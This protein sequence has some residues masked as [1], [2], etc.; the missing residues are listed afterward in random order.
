[1]NTYA[2]K[3]KQNLLSLIYGMEANELKNYVRNPDTDF[4]R[5]RKFG[6]SAVVRFILSMGS[7]TLG[8]EL[9]KF[10]QFNP[11]FPSVSA[12]V[13]QRQKIKPE[14]FE[15][16]FH[17]F[18]S[19]QNKID[20]FD[21]YR[22]LAVDG[23]DVILPLNPDEP[24]A[25]PESRCSILHL[26]ALFD[27]INRQY[28]DAVIQGKRETNEIDAVVTMTERLS[29]QFPVIIVADR[30]YESYNFFAHVEE[31]LFDYVVRIRSSKNRSM[32]SGLCLPEKEAFDI[33]KDVVIT[34]HSTGPYM[35]NKEKYKYMTKQARFD[36]IP[37]SK[38]PD[39]EMSIRFVSFQLETGEF[40]ILA[41][42]LPEEIFSAEQLKEIYH[43]R[44]GIETAFRSVKHITGLTA[45]HTKK[46]DC[47]FQEIYARL[48]MYNFSMLIANKVEIPEE[49]HHKYRYLANFAQA[50]RI[51]MEYFR[52]QNNS[53]PLDLQALLPRFILPERKGRSYTRNVYPQGV[54][55]FNY[56]LS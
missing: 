55:A 51:C 29:E 19:M 18:V 11:D 23:S 45:F 26:N 54:K 10:F 52:I 1:M 15:E 17:R 13:Q 46:A 32:F 40:E 34:R 44:W 16:L 41:T 49:P 38:H 8:Q 39:Y 37:D 50:I 27:I 48:I 42:S 35:V 6:F 4:K 47:A 25:C 22:L 12:F 9:M 30:G 7:S 14:A 5:H 36:F 21:G 31:R 53:P 20:L 43:L 28:L 56:R 3:L 24:F 33:T 2:E